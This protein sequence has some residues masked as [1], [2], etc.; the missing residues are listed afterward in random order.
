MK[1]GILYICTSKYIIFWDSFYRSAE[2]FL[3]PEHEK[4][5]FVFTDGS[6]NTHENPL[7]NVIYQEKLGWPFDTLYRFKIF[8]K[9]ESDLLKMDYLFFF[10]SNLVIEQS[11]GSEILPSDDEELTVTQHPGFFT[12]KRKEFTYE[13]RKKSA[14]YIPSKEGEVYI[15]GGLNGGT[16]Q[17]FLKMA[18]VLSAKIDED[19][20]R[21]IIAIWHDESHINRYIIGEKVKMLPPSYLY[22]EDKS[23]PFEKKIIIL[24]KERFGGHNFLR[25]ISK[26]AAKSKISVFFDR[27]FFR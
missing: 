1:I 20:K 15:A 17:K 25:E 10:N 21:G 11:I 2:K 24:N 3:L 12:K 27:L 6:I 19:Y 23:M 22:P 26:N 18:K 5:Y 9:A 13:K 4:H 16:T 8:L 7:V 14:A